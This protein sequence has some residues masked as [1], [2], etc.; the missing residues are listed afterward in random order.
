MQDFIITQKNNIW[1]GM[2]PRL[3]QA[4]FGNAC[5]CRLHGES[6]MVPGT[7]N[8]ALHV[9]DEVE[10]VLQNRRL[11]AQALGL[12]ASKFTTCEQV[13]GSN[14]AVVDEALVGAGATTLAD[15]IK[16]TDALVTNLA[17]V[18]LLLFFADCVPLLFADER[19]GVC[20]V[21]YAGWRGTVA[22]IGRNTVEAMQQSFGSRPADIVAAIGPSIGQC[23]YEVDDFVRSK[24]AGYEQFFAPRAEKPGKYLLDLWGYNREV[25]LDA[26]LKEENILTAGV[27]TEHNHEMFCSYRAEQG[28]TGRM[29][30]CLYR[31]SDNKNA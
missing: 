31:M 17:N 21:A 24:A 19:Q 18:P 14:V 30:V 25:L 1:W 15:T 23:C 13:H 9:G 6:D 10:L 3:M 12:D 26:G 7:L 8:L 27:C 2:F 20:A 28:K 11:F 22:Q 29:G 4:G 5:S 16:D